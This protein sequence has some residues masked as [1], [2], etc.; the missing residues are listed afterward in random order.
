MWAYVWLR[1][2]VARG[3]QVYSARGQAFPSDPYEQLRAAVYAVFDSWQSDR[4]KVYL[5]VNQI[6]G[7]KVGH[8]G[9]PRRAAPSPRSWV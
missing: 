8:L 7:L 4:A 9:P 1:A 5:A 2:C 6:T 3:A